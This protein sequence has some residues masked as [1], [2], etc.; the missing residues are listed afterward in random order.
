MN[1]YA[2][3]K[4]AQI[5]QNRGGGSFEDN[6]IDLYGFEYKY[7]MVNAKLNA[8]PQR[9]QNILNNLEDAFTQ[10][11]IEVVKVLLKTFGD[12]LAN[13]ALLDPDL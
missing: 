8:T 13:H 6:L 2:L 1:W 12:W 9:K 11:A 4:L 3:Y 5:W 7:A 10:A